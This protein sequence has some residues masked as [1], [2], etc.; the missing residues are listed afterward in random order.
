LVS[1]R[2]AA[3]RSVLWWRCLAFAIAVGVLAAA[4]SVLGWGSARI[5]S[6]R[7]RGR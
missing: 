5:V 7:L 6:R 4:I 3:W 1:H 2:P